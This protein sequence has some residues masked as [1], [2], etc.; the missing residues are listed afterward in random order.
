MVDVPFV[1]LVF[2]GG[3]GGNAFERLKTRKGGDLQN[4]SKKQTLN[5]NIRKTP[6]MFG[7]LP[8]F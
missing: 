5:T 6:K 3:G 4:P 1:I 2:R 8:K 7:G